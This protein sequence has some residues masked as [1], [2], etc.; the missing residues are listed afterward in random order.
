MERAQF[1]IDEAAKE[2]MGDTDNV[3]QKV[4]ELIEKN[5]KVDPTEEYNNQTKI[6]VYKDV[7][8]KMPR[9]NSEFFSGQVIN[10][11]RILS[12]DAQSKCSAAG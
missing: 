2:N 7:V 11:N 10:K 6:E 5:K 1:K 4:E 12:G 3:Q 9:S 8:K